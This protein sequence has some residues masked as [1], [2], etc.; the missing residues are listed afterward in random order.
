MYGQDLASA[1]DF[2]PSQLS[3]HLEG[4][5]VGRDRG[6]APE[7]LGESSIGVVRWIVRGE[8]YWCCVPESLGERSIGVVRRSR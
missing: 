5:S 2:F 3:P 6:Y 4:K 8:Q 1:R 7:S